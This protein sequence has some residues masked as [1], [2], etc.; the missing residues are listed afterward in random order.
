MVP[1]IKSFYST[2]IRAKAPSS[3]LETSVSPVETSLRTS[4]EITSEQ[5]PTAKNRG[6]VASSTTKDSFVVGSIK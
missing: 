3:P 1:E 2:A 4:S 6:R 5:A